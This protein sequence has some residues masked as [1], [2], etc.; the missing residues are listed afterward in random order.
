MCKKA[1]EKPVAK[2]I[3]KTHCK[4]GEENRVRKSVNYLTIDERRLNV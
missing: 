2:V 3:R 1:M 4:E